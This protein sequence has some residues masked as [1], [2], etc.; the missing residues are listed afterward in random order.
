M[1]KANV[2]PSDHRTWAA[3]KPEVTDARRPFL[4]TTH[5]THT[6]RRQRNASSSSTSSKERGATMRGALP[7]WGEEHATPNDHHSMHPH[8]TSRRS[9][10]AMEP[11]EAP[12]WGQGECYSKLR[13][14]QS[15]SRRGEEKRGKERNE[16]PQSN[17]TS[18]PNSHEHTRLK[19]EDSTNGN[20]RTRI[21]SERRTAPVTATRRMDYQKHTRKVIKTRGG[22]PNGLTPNPDATSRPGKTSQGRAPRSIRSSCPCPSSSPTPIQAF[23]KFPS[24]GTTCYSFEDDSATVGKLKDAILARNGTPRGTY[25]LIA[26]RKVL[27]DSTRI[28][29]TATGPPYMITLNIPLVGGAPG[30][31]NTETMATNMNIPLLGGASPGSK[32]ILFRPDSKPEQSSF[33]AGK[34]GDW[35]PVPH[36]PGRQTL[37]RTTTCSCLVI[38]WSTFC[39]M[40]LL[41][42]WVC[43]EQGK[44]HLLGIRD[45]ALTQ[46]AK[47]N[48][49]HACSMYIAVVGF[50]LAAPMLFRARQRLAKRKP[51]QNDGRASGVH[52]HRPPPAHRD[53]EGNLSPVR[54]LTICVEGN[55]GSGKS[56]LL[57]GLEEAGYSVLPEPVDDRW[58]LPLQAF[59]KD[60]LLRGFELQIEV[61]DW[62]RWL[63]DNVLGNPMPK[64]DQHLGHPRRG[65]DLDV[66]AAHHQRL[67]I[68]ERSP[69]AGYYVFSTNLHANGLLP[70]RALR[71]LH[72]VA[73]VWGWIPD[74]T[75]YVDTPWRVALGRVKKR[76][77]ECENEIPANLLQQ[78]E[79]RYEEFIK[80]GPC[81]EV[82]RLDGTKGKKHLLHDARTTLQKILKQRCEVSPPRGA[83]PPTEKQEEKAGAPYTHHQLR[84]PQPPMPP[85]H[86]RKEAEAPPPATQPRRENN[87]WISFAG[88]PY[89]RISIPRSGLTGRELK[90]HVS[91]KLGIPAAVLTIQYKQHLIGGP[92][93]LALPDG[94]FLRINLGLA[95][96]N[97]STAK[98]H[99]YS[100]VTDIECR[101]PAT[102]GGAAS[103][104]HIQKGRLK[105]MRPPPPSRWSLSRKTRNRQIHASNGNPEQC[106]TGPPNSITAL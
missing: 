45:P 49:L 68:V 41:C 43:L 14:E 4:E 11:R 88:N 72:E 105:T 12:K 63:R 98:Q 23:I 56:T 61:L 73:S 82:M 53:I 84:V 8:K 33:H 64:A 46:A 67:S 90:D 29:N 54:S 36:G 99:T 40:L 101:S 51:Q 3:P 76:G 69:W 6:P 19:P 80:W 104:T 13:K 77:R 21:R 28:R 79:C 87:L 18:S 38:L 57:H 44:G 94:A 50:A 75:L 16:N 22:K 31:H 66:P 58:K 96:G 106:Q 24:G 47:K 74:I 32:D 93:P 30:R 86:R 60:P 91:N 100:L 52:H 20:Q 1:S 70:T 42:I 10:P 27:R 71:L 83:Q 9:H 35:K 59:Y 17:W 2:Q 34:P 95:G 39:E 65:T 7:P 25:N 15:R 92:E 5:I 26:D 62:F 37:G 85:M 81:G 97:R 103:A 55:I 78:L 89:E 102:N 48:C